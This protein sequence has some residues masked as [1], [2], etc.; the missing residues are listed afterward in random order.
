LQAFEDYTK[1]IENFNPSGKSKVVW[2]SG[3]SANAHNRYIMTAKV[4]VKRT[5]KNCSS[6]GTYTVPY[7]IHPWIRNN[8]NPLRNNLVPNKDRPH[9]FTVGDNEALVKLEDADPNKFLEGDLVCVSFKAHYSIRAKGWSVQFT[10]LEIVRI[11]HGQNLSNDEEEDDFAPLEVGAALQRKS[12]EEANDDEDQD[13]DQGP[14]SPPMPPPP[15]PSPQA[16]EKRKPSQ[17]VHE[18]D[19]GGKVP[20]HVLMAMDVEEDIGKEP[21]VTME[22]GDGKPARTRRGGGSKR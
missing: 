12:D 13:Q 5:D 2:Q 11:G 19:P 7:N 8:L 14:Q 16:G 17:G 21:D 10:P 3:E 1:A 22:S 9:L 4:F 20:R 15:P 18:G 6:E